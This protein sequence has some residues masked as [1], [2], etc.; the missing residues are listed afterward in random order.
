MTG[1]GA[2]VAA[3]EAQAAPAGGDAPEARP[4]PGFFRYGAASYLVVT[5][6][7]LARALRRSDGHLVYVIDDPAIHLS[8]ARNLAE[9]GTWGV[10]P[11][12][13]ESASSSP[14]WT[15]LVSAWL[16]LVPGPDAV[17]PLVLNVAAGLVVI[18]LL[19]SG[20]R[21]VA[22]SWRRPFDVA[23]VAILVTIVLFLPGLAMTGMEHTLHIALVLG[24]VVLAHRSTTG[25][26]GPGPVWLPYALLAVAT[27]TRFET[28]F[29][30]LGLALALFLAPRAGAGR[31]G[32][33]DPVGRVRRPVLVLASSAVPLGAFAAF[34][35][36]MGQEWLPNSVMAKAAVGTSPS[37]LVWEVLDRFDADTLVACLAAVAVVALVV[38]QRRWASWSFPAIVVVVAI[39]LHMVFARVGWYERYQAYLIALGTY[40]V[41][42]LMGA[43]LPALRLPPAHAVTACGVAVVALLLA[44]DKPQATVEADRAVGETFDQRYQAARFLARYY[45]GR[46]IAT[47]ELGYISLQH[48]G[49]ITDVLGLGDH[50]VLEEWQRADGPPG[51][52][53]WEELVRRRGVDVVAVY[54]DTLD[55][56]EPDSWVQVGQWQLDRSVTTAPSEYFRFYATNPEAVG[57]LREHLAEFE[58]ELPGRVATRL[59]PYAEMQADQGMRRA[60]GDDGERTASGG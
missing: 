37:G 40:F 27:L 5:A 32:V 21:I 20:Q 33:D 6:V 9:H 13:F 31:I 19:G 47:G 53:Y 2:P 28:V 15:V 25:R 3:P 38:N 7:V 17:A 30:A 8:I 29:V 52:A 34:N 49:P 44:G 57:P 54:P 26:T 12:H 23:A 50:E 51:A 39:G 11:G 59:N 41:I 43:E 45:D 35:R 56:A 36:L 24:A 1:L 48:E 46:P 55:G 60:D 16:E 58:D 4:R 22:P 14:V 18:A 10:V 42:E